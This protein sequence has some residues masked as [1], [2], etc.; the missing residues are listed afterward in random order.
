MLLEVLKIVIFLEI[1]TFV[2]W[3]YTELA[4]VCSPILYIVSCTKTASSRFT[5]FMR[6]CFRMSTE[7]RPGGPHEACVG[8]S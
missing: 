4:N 7:S 1:F 2:E 5:I 6:T 3:H 8:I